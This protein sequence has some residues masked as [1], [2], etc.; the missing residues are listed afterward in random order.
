MAVLL[1]EPL[2]LRDVTLRNRIILSPMCEYSSRDGFAND[3]HF[4]HLG[5]RAVG[6]AGAVLTEASAVTADGRI[7]AADLGIYDDGH[8]E[9]LARIFHF[10]EAH[11]A[12]PG[13]QL[14]HAGRKASTSEPW[15]GGTPV[16]VADGGWTPI[17]APSAVA[18][19]DGWQVPRAMNEADIRGVVQAFAAATRRL[20]EAGGRI[21]EI[22][23]AHGYLLHEFLSPLS[24]QRTDRYGGS[25][26][27]RA[28]IV[29]EVVEAV[30]G[31]W[32][33]RLPLFVRISST[34]WV[35]GGWTIEDSVAL[36]R[37][38]KN[39]G[40]DLVDCS[41]GGNVAHAKI[42]IGPGYQVPF[43]ERVRRDAGIPTGAV[44]LI[45]EPAQAEEILQRGQADAVIIARQL[46]RDPYFPLHAAQA[47]GVT[48]PVPNQYLRAF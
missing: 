5:S 24:N 42:P 16:A 22:H 44:G 32:P 23:A 39:H 2:K 4:V 21:A 45:T 15:K 3:W 18:F 43:A 34:D 12:V 38:L 27:N 41:T 19:R 20:V 14:A 28:R 35:E 33:E 47:L 17:W 29:F 9:M 13:M 30:R 40:V 36:A 1:F 25:F 37:Q 46:L 48:P 31:E 26:E 6:G 11:G 8:V 7:S 10:V